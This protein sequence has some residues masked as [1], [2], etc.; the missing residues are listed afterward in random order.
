MYKFL[1]E[2]FEEETEVYPNILSEDIMQVQM[3]EIAGQDVQWAI[4]SII[5]VF[6]YFIFYLRSSFL[7]AMGIMVILLSLPLT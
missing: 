6:I 2:E 7:A 3:Q 4:F 5:F 1:E